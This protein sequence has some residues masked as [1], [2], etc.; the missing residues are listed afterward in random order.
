MPNTTEG[1]LAMPSSSYIGFDPAGVQAWQGNLNSAHEQVI[2][3][4][5]HYRTVA[6]QNNDV[7]HG[8]H[9]QNIN[10][11]CDDITNKH[12]SDHTDLHT[13]YNKASS[14]LVQGVQEVA[15]A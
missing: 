13:Q 12:L 9:F 6:Q 7:A 1:V 10:S 5:N 3:A 4:L 2:T 11:Q 14:D 15:G 8:S